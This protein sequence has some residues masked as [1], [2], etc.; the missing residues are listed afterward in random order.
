MTTV[1]L[2]DLPRAAVTHRLRQASLLLDIHPFVAR[3]GT[4]VPDLVDNLCRLYA[5]FEVLPPDVQADFH[6]RIQAERRMAGG[7]RPQA[8]FYY[9]GKPSFLPLPRHHAL[10][11]LEWG[12]NWCV[13]SHAHQYLIIHA[14]VLALDGRALLLPAPPGSGKSTL[15]AGL[16][17]RGWRLLSDELALLDPRTG[18]VH[19]MSRPVNLKNRSIEVMQQFAPQA[20]FTQPVPDTAKGTVALM[21]APPES[22]ARRR[23]PAQPTW[24]VLPRH[25]QG[26]AARFQ[27][28]DRSQT[29]LLMAEQSFNYDIHGAQGFD[30]LGDL[31]ARC[32][33]LHFE[34]GLLEDAAG[35]FAGLA[36]G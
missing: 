8:R 6:V 25:R 20:L 31:V 30:A 5:D 21:A 10:P 1:R 22:V 14:A 2:A 32:R 33:C 36:N 9:D 23:E 35:C 11:M 18:L 34:Y 27:P 4:D 3:L 7:F 15:T 16:V 24:I 29:L 12:L 26:Q 28:A 17:H 13:A 19:G